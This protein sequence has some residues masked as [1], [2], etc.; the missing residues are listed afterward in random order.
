MKT[1]VLRRNRAGDTLVEVL[2]ATVIL[3]TVVASAYT[4]ANRATRVN[5]ASYEKTK[6]SSALQEQA[7]LLRTVRDAGGTT[8]DEIWDT[9]TTSTSDGTDCKTVTDFDA[10]PTETNY[11]ILT[12]PNAATGEIVR[13]LGTGVPSNNTFARVWIQPVRPSSVTDYTDF[14]I[15]GCWPAQG[16]DVNNFSGLVLRLR[17]AGL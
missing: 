6:M 9:A 5:L 4:L 17:K 11:F 16:G 2:L 8:W 14:G 1:F 10:F 7:E 15:Y 3:S 13:E 12:I